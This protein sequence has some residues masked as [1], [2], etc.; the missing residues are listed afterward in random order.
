MSVPQALLLA[1]VLSMTVTLVAP[2]TVWPVPGGSP[3]KPAPG[4]WGLLLLW[5][6]LSMKTQHEWVP[7]KPLIPPNGQA[8]FCGGGGPPAL[9]ALVSSPSVLSSNC[10]CSI[11]SVPPELVPE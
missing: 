2:E 5:E 8:P 7:V 9:C 11:T 4:A 10:E 3:D 6:S 1:K